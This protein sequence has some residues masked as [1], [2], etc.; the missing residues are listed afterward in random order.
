MNCFRNLK[1]QTIACRL[2]DMRR[3]L[4]Y[5]NC[6]KKFDF[7]QLHIITAFQ[8]GSNQFQ[9]FQVTLLLEGSAPQ[10]CIMYWQYCGTK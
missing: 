6:Y 9:R 2:E 8:G 4:I 10:R 5:L 3:I 1:P 7:P